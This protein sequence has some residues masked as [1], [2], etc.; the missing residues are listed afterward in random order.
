MAFSWMLDRDLLPDWLIRIGIRKLLRERLSMHGKGELEQRAREH[1]DWVREL[2][3][4]PVAIET[5]AANEQ[6]YEVPAA[7]YRRVLGPHLKYSSGLWDADTETLADAEAAMLALATERAEIRDGM[8]VLELGCGWGSWTLWMAQRFPRCTIE[9]VSNSA[10]QREFIEARAAE[11]GLDNIT[12]HTADMRT[13]DTS[14]QFDRVVSTEMFE[15]MR[16]YRELLRRVSNWLVDDGKLFVHIFTHAQ[17][18]YPFETEGEDNWMGRYFFTGGQ[19]PSD[20]LLL[21][22]QENVAIEDHWRVSGEHYAKTSEAWLRNFD[23]HADA[24]RSL[25]AATYGADHKRMFVYWRVFFMACAELWGYRNG[26]EWFVS[27]YRFQ[28]QRNR[29][30]ESARTERTLHPSAT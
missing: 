16:N 28:K 13:F 20:S 3:R 25:F 19:M 7:F 10:S 30:T 2:R 24:I 1:M 22:F 27:H 15:H 11:E 5:D 23:E 9:A 6:H 4:S 21:Y 26:Q 14:E 12:I 18:S 17:Y 29:V 8:R